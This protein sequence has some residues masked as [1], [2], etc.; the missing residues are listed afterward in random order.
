M[1]VSV[2]GAIWIALAGAALAEPA[3]SASA[4]LFAERTALLAIDSKCALLQAPVRAALTA[5]TVQARTGAFRA[6]WT[7]T[8]LDDVSIRAAEAGRARACTD[9][10]VTEAAQRA[11]AGY[12]GWSKTQGID[13]PGV[14]RNWRARRLGDAQGW[15]L[16]QDIA[17]VSRFGLRYDTAHQPMLALSLPLTAAGTPS[18]AQVIIRDRTRAPRPLLNVPGMIA[19]EGLTGGVAPRSLSASWMA[20]AISIERAKDAPPFLLITFP[21]GLLSEMSALDP[22]ESAEITLNYS[23]AASQ[24]YY[25]E[26]GDLNVARAFLTAGAS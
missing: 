13:L 22:R 1:R 11:T 3:S 21:P 2:I 26:I 14:Q 19:G 17:P 4:S 12:T 25:V 7:D 9:P 16:A 18:S 23:G 8:R 24:R 20:N 5:T 15:I 10:L 6:G